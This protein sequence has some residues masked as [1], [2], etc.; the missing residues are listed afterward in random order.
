MDLP[1]GD[2]VLHLSPCPRYI[3]D[4]LISVDEST[5]LASTTIQSNS[6]LGQLDSPSL[7]VLHESLTY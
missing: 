3:L 7:K 5:K 6:S 2:I 1:D 4:S